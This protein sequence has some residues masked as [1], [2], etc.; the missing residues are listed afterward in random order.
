QLEKDAE[1][2]LWNEDV[3]PPGSTF[4]ESLV[5]ALPRF[6]FA[7]L[8]LTP[9]DLVQSRNDEILGPRDNV[10]FELGLFMGH[11]GRSRTFAIHQANAPVKIPT[12][13][14]GVAT[15]QYSWPRSDGSHMAAV[16]AA[17]DG[18]RQAMSVAR[19]QHR[20]SAELQPKS[21]P[22]VSETT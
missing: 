21:P 19:E 8:V 18:I 20:P 10:I 16:G 14:S 4:I 3:F 2:M 5:K 7:V 12:D 6:D 9:D 13:L 11:L 22:E 17:C 1:V 15:L